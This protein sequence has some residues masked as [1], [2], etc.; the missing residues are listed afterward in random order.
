[1]ANVTEMIGFPQRIAWS[2]ST[3]LLGLFSLFVPVLMDG[4]GR[5]LARLPIVHVVALQPWAISWLYK[6]IE[7]EKERKRTKK[8]KKKKWRGGRGYFKGWGG[9]H[10]FP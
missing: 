6:E 10:P 7:R 2:L 3:E 5:R 1:M 9:A 4:N 8:K